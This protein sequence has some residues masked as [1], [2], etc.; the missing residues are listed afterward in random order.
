MRAVVVVFVT[1]LVS[2]YVSNAS[3]P[4]ASDD[5]QLRVVVL[6]GWRLD[7]RS[8]REIE[9]GVSSIL[10]EGELFNESD[11]TVKAPRIRLAGCDAAG[12][13]LFHWYVLPDAETLPP[14][15]RTGFNAR[16]DSPR[17][18]YVRSASD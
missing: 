15:G 17:P 5:L 9:N 7:A 6:E 1:L 13:E 11:R 18:I 8:R 2:A 14:K 10:I 4:P 12:T 16:F 3:E